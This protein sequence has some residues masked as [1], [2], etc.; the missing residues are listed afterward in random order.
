MVDVFS[1]FSLDMQDGLQDD[2]PGMSSGGEDEEVPYR[3]LHTHQLVRTWIQQVALAYN[4]VVCYRS[5]YSR[6][7]MWAMGSDSMRQR[8]KL[9]VKQV[10]K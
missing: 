6:W 8:L 1:Q 10:F 4:F 7:Y 2:D 3:K 9:M 5:G